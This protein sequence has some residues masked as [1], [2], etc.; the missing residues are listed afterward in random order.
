MVAEA[1]LNYDSPCHGAPVNRTV[2]LVGAGS[3]ELKAVG[4]PVAGHH[5]AAGERWSAFRFYAVR[6]SAGPC[7]RPGHCGAGSDGIDRRIATTVP[8][9]SKEVI[10]NRDLA[11]G[12]PSIIAT[13]I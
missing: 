2:V 12:T 6:C 8:H 1:S 4:G 5:R 10:A 11:G 7:P 9:A 13:S 3:G